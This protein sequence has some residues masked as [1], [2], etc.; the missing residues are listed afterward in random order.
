MGKRG[1]YRDNRGEERFWS[2]VDASGDCWT[3]VAARHGESGY[4]VY[5]V[6]HKNILAHRYAYEQLVGPIPEELDLDHLCRNPP[7]VNPDHL[8]PVTRRENLRRGKHVYR[9]RTH[10]KHG[11]PYSEENTY[12]DPRGA[13]WCKTCRR[14]YDS[15]RRPKASNTSQEE[16]AS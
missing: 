12:I 8:E 6:R 11:H 2:K 9:D 7:C 16:Q 13:R 5:S 14:I 3:W 4:G 15:R 10:C 1:P